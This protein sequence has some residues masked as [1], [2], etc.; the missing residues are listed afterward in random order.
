M[1]PPDAPAVPLDPPAL[2]LDSARSAEEIARALEAGD[3][4][5]LTLGKGCFWKPDSRLGSMNG[6]VQTRV[7]YAGGTQQTPEYRNMPGH[8]E[9]TRV[10]FDPDVLAFEVL[11]EDFRD[12]LTPAKAFG[13]KYRPVI[14]AG[15]VE[16]TRLIK[17]WVL[18]LEDESTRPQTAEPSDVEARFWDAERY[19]QKWRLKKANPDLA[20]ALAARLG[21][22]WEENELATTLN[23]FS[24]EELSNAQHPWIRQLLGSPAERLAARASK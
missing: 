19:H 10:V 24:K 14:F 20:T 2:D 16:H 13:S 3:L 12:W 6:V 7:G 1:S 8:A 23:G 17:K 9:V 4:Q 15:S 5:T 22:R 21:Q 11:F 18:T